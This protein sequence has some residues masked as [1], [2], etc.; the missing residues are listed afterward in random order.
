MN[1]MVRGRKKRKKIHLVK[2]YIKPQKRGI[3]EHL[4]RRMKELLQVKGVYVL[5]KKRK[6]R[7]EVFRIG[8][9]GLGE[10][11][12]LFWRLN[13]HNKNYSK[14]E[15]DYFSAFIL[16][17]SQKKKRYLTDIEA[18]GVRIGQPT[19]NKIKGRLIGEY[20]WDKNIRKAIREQNKEARTKKR[21]IEEQ[22]KQ[23]LKFKKQARKARDDL[24]ILKQKEKRYNKKLKKKERKMKSIKIKE[25]KLNKELKEINKL[26]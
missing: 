24:K 12:S 13:S 14:K 2:G 18:L 10:S 9:A 6:R 21:K 11:K 5:Y 4:S 26:L 23:I 25:Q 15:W 20:E 17:I 8:V 1:R 7:M 3:L 22:K 19:V 16:Q